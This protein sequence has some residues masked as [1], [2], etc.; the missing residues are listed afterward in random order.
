[1]SLVVLGMIIMYRGNRW[2][3]VMLCQV[4]EVCG[5]LG[6]SGCDGTAGDCQSWVDSGRDGLGSVEGG[7][8]VVELQGVGGDGVVDTRLSWDDEVVRI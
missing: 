7:H 1:M 5:Q 3:E 6:N 4:M 8:H 2:R